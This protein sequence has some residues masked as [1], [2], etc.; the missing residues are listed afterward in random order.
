MW[1]VHTK[2]NSSVTLDQD[3]RYLCL[4]NSCPLSETQQQDGDI[5]RLWSCQDLFTLQVSC[6]L[7]CDPC[8]HWADPHTQSSPISQTSHVLVVVWLWW[9]LVWCISP[10][11]A[12]VAQL[13]L[14]SVCLHFPSIQVFSA[15]PS[16]VSGVSPVIS[17]AP[18]C[19]NDRD[20]LDSDINC[21]LSS[22][23]LCFLSS[24]STPFTRRLGPR[25]TCT[26]PTQAGANH[27]PVWASWPMRAEKPSDGC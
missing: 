11:D 24:L 26:D 15:N 14:L 27:S 1:W 3:T 23:F 20:H 10:D 17:S 22:L 18:N 7:M 25:I 6:Q 13:T 12:S 4:P 8:Q 21:R 5:I 19:D 2:H 9:Q 16:L